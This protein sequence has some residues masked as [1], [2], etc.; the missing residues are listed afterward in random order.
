MQGEVYIT[1]QMQ[2]KK[3]KDNIH[4][5]VVS[6]DSQDPE[7]MEGEI[8]IVLQVACT[9]LVCHFIFICAIP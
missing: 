5:T 6:M 9:V 7:K 1:C 2:K 3:K 8:V 4:K